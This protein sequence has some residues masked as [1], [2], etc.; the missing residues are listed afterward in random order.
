MASSNFLLTLFLTHWLTLRKDL[1]HGLQ[2]TQVCYSGVLVCV[3]LLIY[4][5]VILKY[6]SI[7]SYLAVVSNVIENATAVLRYT[8]L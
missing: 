2:N 7:Q 8:T 6:N 4:Y 1:E 3:Q 5:I